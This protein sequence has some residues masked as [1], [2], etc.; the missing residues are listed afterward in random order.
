MNALG[1]FRGLKKLPAIRKLVRYTTRKEIRE[2][3]ELVHN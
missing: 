2:E 1:K 3:Q